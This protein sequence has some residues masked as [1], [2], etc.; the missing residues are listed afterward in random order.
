M[1]IANY[2][3]SGICLFLTLTDLESWMRILLLSLGV[4]SGAFSLLVSVVKWYKAAKADGSIDLDEIE[5]LVT[6]IE[7]SITEVI[8]NVE[9]NN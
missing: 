6:T 5:E 3:A 9:N 4:L 8:A 2:L 7:D 1:K